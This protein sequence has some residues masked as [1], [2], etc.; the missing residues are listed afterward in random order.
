MLMC[1]RAVPVTMTMT[2][3]TMTTKR[4]MASKVAHCGQALIPQQPLPP[5]PLMALRLLA[6]DCNTMA[7]QLA[8]SQ[9][10]VFAQSMSCPQLPPAPAPAAVI[11]NTAML[12]KKKK[13]KKKKRRRRRRR[14][15]KMNHHMQIPALSIRNASK[16]E[17][18]QQPHHDE[19][20]AHPTARRT[21]MTT[22]RTT[23]TPPC[24]R[25][26]HHQPPLPPCH[27]AAQHSRKQHSRK[28]QHRH[29]RRVCDPRGHWRRPAKRQFRRA[30]VRQVRHLP[31]NRSRGFLGPALT[32]QPLSALRGNGSMAPSC[33]PAT[34]AR[35]TVSLST[36]RRWP[37]RCHQCRGSRWAGC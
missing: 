34:C 11:A 28:Q 31:P 29:R 23:P 25:L 8:L 2:M 30:R 32:M 16:M 36:S 27:L 15:R 19:N 26:H 5:A 20:F 37:K 21:T 18:T 9:R 17:P 35:T 12:K 6:V 24:P 1:E 10:T 7:H 13:K 33:L 22:K 3:T 14:R 4:V